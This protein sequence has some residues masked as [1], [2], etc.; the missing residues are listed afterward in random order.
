VLLG[1]IPCPA[2]ATCNRRAAAAAL[3]VGRVGLVVPVAGHSVCSLGHQ[4]WPSCPGPSL[5]FLAAQDLR[6]RAC[7]SARH[8]AHKL[9]S[10][11]GARLQGTSPSSTGTLDAL[12]HKKRCSQRVPP[13]A[14]NNRARK[15]TS[16]DSSGKAHVDVILA[17]QLKHRLEEMWP[18]SQDCLGARAML[19]CDRCTAS[20]LSLQRAEQAAQR[21]RVH[22]GQ[23]EHHWGPKTQCQ[24]GN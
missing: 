1:S 13:T 15:T 14:S 9:P 19:L 22:R 11:S 24:I 8:L 7:S 5:P 18:V 20:I 6:F 2:T 4:G 12:K 23:G 16:N 10:H 21:G 17:V 3:R